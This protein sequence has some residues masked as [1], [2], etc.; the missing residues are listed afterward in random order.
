MQAREMMTTE[1]VTVTVDTPLRQVARVLLD[2]GIN[3]VPV[4]DAEGAPI[5]MVSDGDLVTRSELE[6]TS[7][8]DWW[9]KL[10]VDQSS[11]DDGVL[12]QL[13]SPDRTAG[14]VMATPVVT[15]GE[16]TDM[17]EVARLLAAHRIKRVPV[18]KDGQVTGIVSR[19]DLLR[20]VAGGASGDTLEKQE[21]E[22]RGF[23]SNLF[24]E[25]H[26]PAWEVVSVHSAAELVPDL[27][28][29]AATA[30]G[31]R[32]LESD[33]HSSETRHHDDARLAAEKQ[34]QETAKV[35]IDTHVSDDA[36]KKILQ[37]AREA[38]GQGATEWLVLRFPNQLC[39]DGG[40]AIN[41]ADAGW[42]AT[43]RGEA[44]ELYLRWEQELKPAGF[45]LSA[46]VLEFPGGMPGD[47][48]MF[49]VW[50]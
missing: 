5:G 25:Y 24:G 49:L 48:G 29:T 35:L 19:A 7:R 17:A 37:H 32:S 9:L 45:G 4:L 6:R 46:H 28:E 42:P 34:R 16:A 38:A 18:L 30:S 36:W 21:P 50:G 27:G 14:D 31:F 15:V 11:P 12:E 13:R 26:R 43:L 8:R 47:I 23:L 44:A 39:S 41:I 2:H 33:F 10:F 1:V 20:V 22:H 40:R 3:A